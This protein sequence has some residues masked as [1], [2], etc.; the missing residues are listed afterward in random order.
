MPFKALA[1][2]IWDKLRGLLNGTIFMVV[3]Q[4]GIIGL[5]T[6]KNMPSSHPRRGHVELLVC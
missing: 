6:E 1:L 2:P 4:F 5:T 3:C